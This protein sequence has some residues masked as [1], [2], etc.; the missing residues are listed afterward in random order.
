MRLSIPCLAQASKED[1]P[2]FAHESRSSSPGPTCREKAGPRPPWNADPCAYPK[3]RNPI[4]I[5][6]Y[7]LEASASPQVSDEIPSSQ[8]RDPILSEQRDNMSRSQ[9]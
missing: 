3:P 8:R 2:H 7:D 9:A 6:A 4:K 1:L 5:P